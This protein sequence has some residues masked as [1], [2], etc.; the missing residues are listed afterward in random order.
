MAWVTDFAQAELA[1]GALITRVVED[2]EVVVVTQEGKPSVAMIAADELA[3][4]VECAH[5]MRSPA[6]AQRL[7]DAWSRLGLSA[8]SPVE[9]EALRRDLDLHA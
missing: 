3:S 5:L 2:R 7:L 6:N 1:L 8:P 9:V 4:L